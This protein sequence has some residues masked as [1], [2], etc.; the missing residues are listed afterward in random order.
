LDLKD[1]PLSTRLRKAAELVASLE[2]EIQAVSTNASVLR[3]ASLR[4]GREIHCLGD[5]GNF[6]CEARIAAGLTQYDA[7]LK[8][9]IP[10]QAVSRYEHALT[11]PRPDTLFSLLNLYG[12]ELRGCRR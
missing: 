8:L 6:L 5:F 4:Q 1:E 11:F 9:G 2:A 7:A 3:F 12:C 10:Q